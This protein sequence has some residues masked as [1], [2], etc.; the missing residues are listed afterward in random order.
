MSIIE[1]VK[2]E[3]LSKEIVNEERIL[4]SK[5]NEI[6]IHLD[7][8]SNKNLSGKDAYFKVVHGSSFSKSEDIARISFYVPE[9]VIH[10]RNRFGQKNFKLKPKEKDLLISILQQ[11]VDKDDI[12]GVDHRLRK[13]I[14]TNW[15]LLIYYFNIHIHISADQMLKSIQNDY[16][17]K[18]LNMI[19]LDLPMPDYTQL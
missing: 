3:L 6:S 16:K 8:D 1:S 5:N 9:Y 14:L 17:D 4:V 10:N 13:Y 2:E 11:E 19:R 18:P 12:L 15:N 7:P